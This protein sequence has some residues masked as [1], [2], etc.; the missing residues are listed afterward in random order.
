MPTQRLAPGPPLALHVETGLVEPG[1]ALRC[2]VGVGVA[3]GGALILNQPAAGVFLAVGAVSAGFGSFQGAYR[4]RAAIMLLAAAG[5]ALSLFVG[6]LA[7][8]STIVDCAI[9]AAWGLGAGLL[10]AIGPAASFI[11]LQSTV[12]VLIATAYPADVTGAAGRALF[13]LAG[14]T[15]QTILVVMLWP[16][17]RFHAERAVVSRVYNSLADYAESLAHTPDA[18][19]EPHTL[20]GIRPLQTDPSRSHARVKCWSSSHCWTRQTASGRASPP[21]RWRLPTSGRRSPTT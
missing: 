2:A 21:C 5:M 15:I 7:G 6:S 16:L 1:S 12:A 3:L 14:G 17:R 4:S 9:A 8:R 10:V 13:V 18:P 19:P 11:G 20:A